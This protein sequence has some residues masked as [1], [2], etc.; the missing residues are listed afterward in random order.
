[1]DIPQ[2]EVVPDS[3]TAESSEIPQHEVVPDNQEIPQNEVV[4]DSQS[5]LKYGTPMQQGITALE[6]AGKGATFGLSTKAEELAGVNPQDIAA[7][8]QENPMAAIGGEAAGTIGSMFVPG[9]GEGWLLGK[10]AKALVPIAD[11]A[12]TLA[13]VGRLAL[14]GMGETMGF[15]S[16]DELSD[17]FLD[18]GHDAA[19][20]ANHIIGSGAT[21]FLTGGAFGAA[22]K[23]LEAIQ[24]TKLGEYLDNFA[25]GLGSASNG[26]A[27]DLAKIYDAA[28]LKI[29]KGIIHGAKFYDETSKIIAKSIADAASRTA[30]SLGG[31]AIGGGLGSIA[32]P[33]GAA[34]GSAAG[35][36]IGYK[37]AKKWLDPI[38]EDLASKASP[39][40]TKKVAVPI[41][42]NAIQTG[43]TTG[44]SQALNY[45][46]KAAAG[47]NALNKSL[48]SLFKVGSE[49]AM[50]FEFN[51]KDN[52]KLNDYIENGGIDQQIQQLQ[53]A[54]ESSNQYAEGGKVN[55]S[56]KPLA[57]DGIS[58]LYPTQHMMLSATKGRVSNYL[59]SIR[60]LPPV[61]KLI[62][63]KQSK[64][65]IQQKTYENALNI[66][67]QPL[68]IL[69]HIQDGTLQVEHV[70]HLSQMYPEVHDHLSNKI[71][72]RLVDHQDEGTKPSYKVRQGLSLFLGA[73]LETMLTPDGIQA[74]QQGFM[75]KASPQ[76]GAQSQGKTKKGTSSLGKDNKTYRTASQAA[77]SDRI[78]RDS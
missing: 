40:L 25:I 64:D 21:G 74:A 8:Q 57:E 26:S 17:A 30:G 29:P 50:N 55:V 56:P 6:G 27:E 65:P 28:G 4:P 60:P 75:P 37:I 31:A 5:K 47:A 34:A 44:I 48:D 42:L 19:G 46:T 78:S 18:K 53:N 61:N 54:P 66:A 63:D 15:A 38:S 67:N 62:F 36:R 7:R 73:P 49:K 22:G 51:Q 16:G 13:K 41:M 58:K 1:M 72:E 70:K 33:A 14:R 71:T 59:N 3:Q 68:S 35:T 43:Q 24:N 45:G 52:D 20:V 32:G 76:G 69:K 12:S 11:E 10:A 39:W 9:V 23:G 77:E 2:N